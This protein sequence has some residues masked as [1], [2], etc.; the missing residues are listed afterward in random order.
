MFRCYSYTI[1]RERI[2]FCVALLGSRQYYI[3]SN[4]QL[5][6]GFTLHRACKINGD[7]EQVTS[8]VNNFVLYS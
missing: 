1:I 3:T 8:T 4:T 6:S 2:N 5:T 7:P